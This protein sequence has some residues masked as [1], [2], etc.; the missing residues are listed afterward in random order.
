MPLERVLIQETERKLT[1]LTY[2][3]QIA[4][5]EFEALDIVVIDFVRNVQLGQ[6]LAQGFLV[7]F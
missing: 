2:L 6:H 3:P 1:I 4:D 5:K 7:F